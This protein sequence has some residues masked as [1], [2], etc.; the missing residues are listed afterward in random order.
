MSGLISRVISIKATTEL[1]IDKNGKA[2]RKINIF[3]PKGI[4]PYNILLHP[5]Y[6][7]LIHKCN[8]EL[9]KIEKSKNIK[10]NSSSQI[11][12]QNH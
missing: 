10:T 9:D 7:E 4:D 8:C 5:E 1:I 3:I 12:F 6:E 11:L 2:K